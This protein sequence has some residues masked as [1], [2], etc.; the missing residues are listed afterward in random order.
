MKKETKKKLLN[1]LWNILKYAITA[2][3]GAF[4]YS[5]TL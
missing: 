3:L 1:A 4:G 2:V 5:I